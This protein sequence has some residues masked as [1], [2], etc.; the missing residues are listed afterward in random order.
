MRE[1]TFFLVLG[2]PVMNMVF[3]SFVN[4]SQLN[5]IILFTNVLYTSLCIYIVTGIFISDYKW[6]LEKFHILTT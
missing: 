1:V 2:I 3:R 5:F 4:I 6:Y